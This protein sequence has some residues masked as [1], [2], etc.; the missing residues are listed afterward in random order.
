MLL[1]LIACHKPTPNPEVVA[2]VAEPGTEAAADKVDPPKLGAPPAAMPTF[3]SEGDGPA[4]CPDGRGAFAFWVGEY[5]MPILDVGEAVTLRGKTHPCALDA[6][7]ACTV[8]PGLYH[9]WVPESTTRFATVQPILRYEVKADQEY[10]GGTLKA[11]TEL[12]VISY[13]AEGFCLIQQGDGPISD[14]E[15]P[16]ESETLVKVPE[17]RPS[18]QLIGVACT[19]GSTVW[20]EDS[21]L[22]AA[23]GVLPGELIGYG[24]VGPAQRGAA[25]P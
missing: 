18:T 2:S 1:L 19:E 15:C 23:K 20:I 8:A 13:L 14:A 6:A 3:P 5:P 16:A 7:A 11:G 25:Q 4:M 22:Q 24:E 10:A 12:K 9:P 21:V 17:T